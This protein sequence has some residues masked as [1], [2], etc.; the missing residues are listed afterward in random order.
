VTTAEATLARLEAD[1]ERGL[2][3]AEAARRLTQHGPNELRKVEKTPAWRMFLAQFND[4]MIWV[5]MAAVVISAIEHQTL[6]AVAITAI[7]LLN[8]VLGFVQEYRAEQ[9][10][11][12]LKQMSAPTATVIRGG[13]EQ[14]V[15]AIDLVPGDIVLIES[16]DRIPADG[17]LVEDAALRVEEASLT[18]E[19]RPAFKHA[20]H[21]C[22]LECAL[23]D[24][25]TMVFAGTAVAVG[26]GTY[27]VTHTGQTT[28]MGR[29]ADLIAAQEDE[30]TPLQ[31]ELKSIGKQ[32]ALLVLG[33]AAV[34]FVVG[35]VQAFN[36]TGEADF[37]A[38]LAHEAFRSRLT[39]A[40][41]VAISLAVAAIP[42]GLPAIVTVA[43][44]LGVRNMAERNAI[45]R[46]LHAVETLG[47]TTFICSDKTGT[48]TRNEMTVRRVLVGEDLAEV[49]PDWALAPEHRTPHT[50]DQNL[51]LEIAASC[52][53]AHFT[54]DDTLVGDPTE[55]AL[56]VAADELHEGRRRPRRIAEVPFDSERKRMTTV[57]E[58]DGR[59][60]AYVKGGGDV[61][62]DL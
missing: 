36:A 39:V 7:L 43:L 31:R 40:L 12:A 6:E 19:S 30:K 57:H 55:T 3:P 35:A 45:V 23:G 47:S 33:I 22:E 8:G 48:L 4:F 29:I 18:G 1:S 2:D 32:I 26:R 34:V 13:V 15:N 20:D 53:D 60:V 10:L 51:L 41:L 59:R 17:R 28:Q 14:E 21:T 9:A 56:I 37:F 44:S 62:L 38:A 16:G 49:T 5:L 24:R 58:V 50:D 27:V 42:E 25:T 46:K 52:N 54:A 11:E 61:V